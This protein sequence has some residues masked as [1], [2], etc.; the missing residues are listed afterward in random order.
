MIW[1]TIAVLIALAIAALITI[2]R[3]RP[4]TAHPEIWCSDPMQGDNQLIHY[5]EF[6][7]RDA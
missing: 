3:Q 7:L 4:H 1:P 5:C 2:P 6:K